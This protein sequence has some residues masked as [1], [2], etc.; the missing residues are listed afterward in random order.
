MSGVSGGSNLSTDSPV[1][2]QKR[3]QSA[4]R[5]FQRF[6]G[7]L[8][9]GTLNLGVVMRE[10]DVVT[11]GTFLGHLCPAV[12]CPSENREGQVWVG[13]DVPT[14]REETSCFFWVVQ[15]SKVV[16][17]CPGVQALAVPGWCVVT[18][19]DMLAIE[20]A[21]VQT[22]VWERRDG[23]RSESRAWRFADVDGLKNP[24]KTQIFI[25]KNIRNYSYHKFYPVL[26][27]IRINRVLL[28]FQ[29]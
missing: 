28:Y 20:V 6:T 27:K 25:K 14:A 3:F 26:A 22:G 7:S 18:P 11:A 16:G 24:D 5:K 29:C 10:A 1:R 17:C 4:L 2:R 23:R 19:V 15:Q 8:W 12:G 21:N 9:A 13:A